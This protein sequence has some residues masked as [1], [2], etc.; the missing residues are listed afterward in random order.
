M[1][2]RQ[3]ISVPNDGDFHDRGRLVA[4]Q[5]GGQLERDG[6]HGVDGRDHH[7]RQE[8]H[9]EHHHGGVFLMRAVRRPLGM[10]NL[11]F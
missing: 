8:L 5:S 7:G 11:L 4:L 1:V 9:G 6:V 10:N 3:L 2:Q